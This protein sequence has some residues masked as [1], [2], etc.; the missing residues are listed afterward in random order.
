MSM[1]LI[2]LLSLCLF[3]TSGW[4]TCK[5]TISSWNT[6][7]CTGTPGNIMEWAFPIGECVT[8]G[9]TSRM[10]ESCS[11]LLDFPNTN[12]AGA[13]YLLFANTTC[14]GMHGITSTSLTC[15]AFTDIF[16]PFSNAP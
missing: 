3:V 15:E 11:E 12:C 4:A 1:K 16:L 7:D 14:V 2:A 8:D 13:P 9:S 10:A 6:G 5:C